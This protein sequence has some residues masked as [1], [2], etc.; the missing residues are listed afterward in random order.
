M[1]KWP[2]P[3]REVFRKEVPIE[4]RHKGQNVIL[5]QVQHKKKVTG[6]R[7]GTFHHGK[8][9]AK[10]KK[11]QNLR[12]TTLLRT[13]NW[14]LDSFPLW[15]RLT[16]A[17]FRVVSS[18]ILASPVWAP[19]RAPYLKLRKKYLNFKPIQSNAIHRDEVCRISNLGENGILSVSQDG[20]LAFWKNNLSLEKSM[21]L[22][23]ANDDPT[24]TSKNTWITD[25]VVVPG[26]N[27]QRWNFNF[28]MR[29][30]YIRYAIFLT[31]I[32]NFYFYWW[33]RYYDLRL[34][35]TRIILSNWWFEF[36]SSPCQSLRWRFQSY[37]TY[38]RW[39]GGHFDTH[40]ETTWWYP[41]VS[42]WY[43]IIL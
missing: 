17:F 21:K 35:I 37:P 30:L 32:K 14:C 24:R 18:A 5:H 15:Y 33:S 2:N 7:W 34:D 39:K 42:S 6:N 16:Y 28:P 8:V 38:G 19:S 29:T 41:K 43:Q 12:K 3:K 20:T 4:F 36:C 26:H 40:H 10:V 11:S 13:A 1:K 23:A 9:K 27:R 31:T 22:G 25:C